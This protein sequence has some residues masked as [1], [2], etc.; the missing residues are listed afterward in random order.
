MQKC[1]CCVCELESKWAQEDPE[2]T[3]IVHVFLEEWDLASLRDLDLRQFKL[4]LKSVEEK[5]REYDRIIVRMH[6]NSFGFKD[7]FSKICFY[8]EREETFDE[9]TERLEIAKE[10]A[11]QN[12]ILEKEKDR[13]EYDRLK[14]KY[15]W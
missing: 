13:K 14:E 6:P 4:M 3:K 8:G 15:G 2:T 7:S 10:H 5:W 11:L 1:D 12:A 9:Y